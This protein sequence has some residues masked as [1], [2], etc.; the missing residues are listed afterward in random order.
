MESTRGTLKLRDLWKGLIIAGGVPALLIVQQSIAAG[1][2][3]FNWKQ[4][5]MAAIAGFVTYILKNL[6][7]NDV[8]TAQKILVEAKQKEI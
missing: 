8:A 5:A 2:F 4:I 1:D 6:L 3:V 7:T